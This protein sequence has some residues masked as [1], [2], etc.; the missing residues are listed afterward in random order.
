MEAT[1][2]KQ[3]QHDTR[4]QHP[5]KT[6]TLD[7]CQCQ[8]QP[9]SVVAMRKHVTPHSQEG[10]QEQVGARDDHEETRQSKVQHEQAEVPV[11]A[12]AH[13]VVDP[14][15]VMVH[16]CHTTLTN[17]AMMRSWRLQPIALVALLRRRI[18]LHQKLLKLFGFLAQKLRRITR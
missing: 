17:T 13:T 15:A 7:V 4:G 14:G 1:Q 18:R 6:H 11:V 3:R 8:P 10:L 12:P 16:L 2:A 9:R 5:G